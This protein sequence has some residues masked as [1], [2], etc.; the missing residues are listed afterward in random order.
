[1]GFLTIGASTLV[2]GDIGF[3]GLLKGQHYEQKSSDLV[4]LVE[5][6]ENSETLSFSFSVFVQ[7][8]T[9]NVLNSGFVR[10]PDNSTNNLVSTQASQ[11]LEYEYGCETLFD[12]D[13]ERPNGLYTVVV[14]TVNNGVY[15][16]TLAISGDN[17]PVLPPRVSNFAALQAITN[18]AQEIT[19]QWDA[20][21]GCT[22]N[23]FVM[24]TVEGPSGMGWET[25]GFGQPGALNGTNTFVTLPANTLNA[26]NAYDVELMVVRAVDM[27]FEPVVALAAYFVRT[28]LQIYTTPLTQSDFDFSVPSR[29]GANAPVDSSVAFHFTRPMDPAYHSITWAGTNLVTNNFVYSWCDANRVLICSYTNEFPNNIDIT[30]TLHLSGFRDAQGNPLTNEQSG[31]FHT[32]PSQD[33]QP[34][35]FLFKIR[36]YRQLADTPQ[37]MGFEGDASVE[38]PAFN[39]LIPP[40]ML[41]NSNKVY[42]LQPEEWDSEYYLDAT[43]ATQAQLDAFLPNGTYTLALPLLGGGTNFVTMELGAEDAYPQAPTIANLAGLQ[44]LNVSN[45]IVISW[46]T[47]TNF[48]PIVTNGCSLIEVGICNEED[49]EELYWFDP[50]HSNVTAS[51]ITIPTNTLWPGRTYQVNLAFIHV[52]D[53]KSSEQGYSVGAFATKTEFTIKTAGT[54]IMPVPSFQSQLGGV[55][56]LFEGGEPNRRYVIETST[57]LIRWI[58]QLDV[59]AN[60]GATIWY[61]DLDAQFLRAR[62]YRLR[63]WLSAD[64][65]VEPPVSIQGTIWTDNSGSK[66]PVVGAQ[67]GTSLDGQVTVTDKDG[68]FF[69]ETET[70]LWGQNPSYT[71]TVRSGVGNRDF[72]P[73]S[74]G[75]HPRQQNFGLD[76]NFWT[77]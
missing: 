4:S 48:M 34:G 66:T 49:G 44:N 35:A 9:S 39:Q 58:P 46:A 74:W 7:G 64:G 11:A 43:Y 19:I 65:W 16:N 24:L 25:P 59:Q 68:R 42:T 38:F 36:N 50:G 71:I 33:M 31:V 22:S 20:I 67:V 62:F 15:S 5:V 69:L 32:I 54:P 51:A 2:A 10:L 47:L 57:D 56:L 60:E 55:A 23:D 27:D 1:L 28:D 41:A 76:G 45:Q 13:A 17:Y 12:L 52:V 6:E 21:P 73:F 77:P 61:S 29:N 30:W 63:D 53:Y 3:V 37:I 70:P 72:G 14:Q 8:T 26:G 40:V 18:V 75:H